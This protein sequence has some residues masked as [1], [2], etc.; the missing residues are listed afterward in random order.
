MENFLY[1]KDG[2][3][4]FKVLLSDILYAKADKKYIHIITSQ[5][6]HFIRGSISVLQSSF[7]DNDQF[8]RI[9]KSYLVSLHHIN[10]YDHRFVSI[11]EKKLP[12]GRHYRETLIKK[13]YQ[14]NARLTG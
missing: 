11:G 2:N 1:I 3:F 6:S 8:C 10:G 12:I 5:T 9:H 7:S 14:N 13:L 4:S